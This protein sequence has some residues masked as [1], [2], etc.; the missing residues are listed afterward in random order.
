VLHRIEVPRAS[1]RP[2][3]PFATPSRKERASACPSDGHDPQNN[4]GN[5]FQSLDGSV[6]DH[7]DL[8]ARLD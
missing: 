2:L 6:A 7:A 4:L 3:P 1:K 8:D 5:A